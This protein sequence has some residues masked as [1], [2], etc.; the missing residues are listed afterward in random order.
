MENASK[1]LLIAGAILL[2]MIIIGLAVIVVFRSEILSKWFSEELDVASIQVHNNQ[3]MKY[4][5]KNKEFYE[6]QQLL[7]DIIV[8]N[9]KVESKEFYIQIDTSRYNT[10]RNYF[11]ERT[12]YSRNSNLLNQIYNNP[13]GY[14]GIKNEESGRTAESYLYDIICY[15]NENGI[16]N[17]VEIIRHF[18]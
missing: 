11:Y 12:F 17:K 10:T 8:A 1:A 18:N 13:E 14:F 16:I 5:G 4:E 6:V 9:K 2:V 3:F 15:K 7:S